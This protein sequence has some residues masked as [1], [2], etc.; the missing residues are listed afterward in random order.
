MTLMAKLKLSDITRTR[1][2]LTVEESLRARL[3][4]HL[5]E[6]QELIA[7][8]LKGETL[9]KSRKIYVTNDAGERVTQDAERRMRKWYWQDGD[10]TWY[11]ELRYGGKVM[12]IVGEKAAIEAGK[13]ND[14]PKIIDTVIEAVK[15]GELDGALLTAKKARVAILR[16]KQ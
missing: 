11:F 12:N 14:I 1:Q 15:A 2:T 3:L 13:I 8:E 6:Q 7:A 5:T 9:V 16:R 4:G 10:G